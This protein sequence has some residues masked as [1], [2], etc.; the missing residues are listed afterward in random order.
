MTTAAA[1]TFDPQLL[2]LLRAAPWRTI[3]KRFLI[4]LVGSIALHVL[5]A[6]YIA[7]QPMPVT[8]ERFDELQD[9][10]AGRVT[11]PPLLPI[12]KA[13]VALAPSVRPTAPTIS[14]APV[15]PVDRT[16]VARAAVVKI[17]G[18]AGPGGVFSDLL[19]APVDEIAHAL[20]GAKAVRVTASVDPTAPK[21]PATGETATI[22]RLGTAGVRQV[23]IGTRFDKAP[24]TAVPGTI[25]VDDPDELDP[26]VLQQFITA[27]RAAVQSCYERALHHNP[28]MKGGKVVLRMAIG[29]GGRVSG[30]RVEED[31]LG[32]D[33]VA[34]C[35]S[36]L[37]SRWIFPVS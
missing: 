30:L 20:D 27:R 31:T 37:M 8:E 4:I 5:F 22:E 3:E 17:L 24:A 34:S 10:F 25:V 28:A 33:A 19:D 9:R 32:S 6:S 2:R 23:A 21:G 35:M 26:R 29:T 14:R 16:Q 13:P 1:E 7:A 15:K 18:S 11:L 12:P 36:T